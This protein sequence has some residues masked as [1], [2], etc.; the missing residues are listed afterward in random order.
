[1]DAVSNDQGW[2]VILECLKKQDTSYE[3]HKRV[4]LLAYRTY[5]QARLDLVETVLG[6]AAKRK[7]AKPGGLKQ[8][9][10]DDA[11]SETSEFLLGNGKP[12]KLPKRTY[13]RLQKGDTVEIHLDASFLASVPRQTP[14]YPGAG[15]ALSPYRRKRKRIYCSHGKKYRGPRPHR[16]CWGE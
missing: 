16:G 7:S 2:R 5:L 15:R 10:S 1:M 8:K 3:A 6:S 4:G 13:T 12:E 14:F 9:A 11:F